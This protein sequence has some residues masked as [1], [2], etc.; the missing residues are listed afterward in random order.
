MVH[1]HVDLDHKTF[2]ALSKLETEVQAVIGDSKITTK[3]LSQKSLLLH[4]I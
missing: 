4:D 1:H 3:S 2:A